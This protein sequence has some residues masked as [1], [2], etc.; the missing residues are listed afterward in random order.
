MFE[1]FMYIFSFLIIT[2]LIRKFQGKNINRKRF[3]WERT[4]TILALCILGIIFSDI[5]FFAAIIGFILA[6]E[7]E[8]HFNKI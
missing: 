7:S 6:D 3:F 2:L 1:I 5:N 4:T 8:N